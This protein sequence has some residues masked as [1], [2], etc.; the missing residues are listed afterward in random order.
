MV[1]DLI[2]FSAESTTE[3]PLTVESRVSLLTTSETH[4]AS[5]YCCSALLCSEVVLAAA[6]IALY[7]ARF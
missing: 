5:V 4:A 6:L 2:L 7:A 3:W 1:E